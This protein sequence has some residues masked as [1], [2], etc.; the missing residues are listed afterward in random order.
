M[1]KAAKAAST[2]TA[3][4]RSTCATRS[5]QRPAEIGVKDAKDASTQLVQ[6]RKAPVKA[7]AAT[8]AKKR[9]PVAKKSAIQHVPL[10][11]FEHSE[12]EEKSEEESEEEPVATSTPK[13]S[14]K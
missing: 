2:P 11:D 5:G 4:G 12:S 10:T 9:Q 1:A 13:K 14:R 7:K 8:P 6:K 3:S